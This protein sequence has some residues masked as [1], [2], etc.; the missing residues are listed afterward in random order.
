MM[1][2]SGFSSVSDRLKIEWTGNH[3]FE[4]PALVDNSVVKNKHSTK[5]FSSVDSWIRKKE[6]KNKKNN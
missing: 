3:S 6:R 1:S 2:T 4:S 5:T